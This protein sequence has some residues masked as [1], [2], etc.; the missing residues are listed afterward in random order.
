LVRDRFG[1]IND[2]LNWVDVY[3]QLMDIWAEEQNG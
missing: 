1:S 2:Y 3:L